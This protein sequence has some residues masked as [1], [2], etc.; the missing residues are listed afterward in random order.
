MSKGGSGEAVGLKRGS[1]VCTLIGLISLKETFTL[2]QR[3]TIC[4]L[5]LTCQQPLHS[6]FFL[7]FPHVLS[8]ILPFFPPSLLPGHLATGRQELGTVGRR[9]PFFSTP[10]GDLP[11]QQQLVP[12]Q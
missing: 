2:A 12:N 11:P 9:C 3:S 6:A 8:L 1:L 4:V 7:S 5:Y 10:P